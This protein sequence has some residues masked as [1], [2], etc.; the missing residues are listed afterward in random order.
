MFNIIAKGLIAEVCLRRLRGLTTLSDDEMR[1]A[2]YAKAL[3]DRRVRGSKSFTLKYGDQVLA[4]SCERDR[5]LASHQ[6]PDNSSRHVDQDEQVPRVQNDPVQAH[7]G[8]HRWG[9]GVGAVGVRASEESTLSASAIPC[10]RVRTA[11]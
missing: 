1:R 7:Q 5:W 8:R 6:A 3:C 10:A 2:A 9:T 11:V 4:L